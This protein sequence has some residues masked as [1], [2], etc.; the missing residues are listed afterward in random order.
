[1]KEA[2]PYGAML[3]CPH[4]HYDVWEQWRKAGGRA[5][6][7]GPNTRN[8]RADASCMT[9][10]VTVSFS[11]RTLKSCATQTLIAEIYEN[12]GCQ[13]NGLDPKRD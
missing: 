12:S 8:G 9:R 2:E 11:M 1:M 13:W 4:G 7:A 3:T 10:K 6:I 5:A